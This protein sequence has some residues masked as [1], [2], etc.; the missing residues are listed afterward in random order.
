MN[1]SRFFPCDAR[2]LCNVCN[3]LQY[4]GDNCTACGKSFKFG[5]PDKETPS[6]QHYRTDNKTEV[7]NG[8]S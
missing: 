7:A 6:Y 1:Y 5:V 2:V 4:L 8:N 3:H